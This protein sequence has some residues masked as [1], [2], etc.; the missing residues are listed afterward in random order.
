MTG[1]AM[2][3]K[4]ADSKVLQYDTLTPKTPI[5][6]EEGRQN[7]RNPFM[8]QHIYLSHPTTVTKHPAG[9]TLQKTQQTV[10]NK[11][12]VVWRI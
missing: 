11:V 9:P 12:F 1:M 6:D 5:Q 2:V 4:D 7:D 10:W 8:G 3:T